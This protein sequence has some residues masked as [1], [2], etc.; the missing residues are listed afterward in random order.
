MALRKVKGNF[1]RMFDKNLT[2]LVRGIRN[3]K[4]NEVMPVCVC[5]CVRTAPW[6][7]RCRDLTSLP[8]PALPVF[9]IVSLKRGG[10]L[11][12]FSVPGEVHRAVYRGDQAGAAAGQC[13]GQSQR[14]GQADIC[15]S[16]AYVNFIWAL[17]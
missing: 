1:E 9:I 4:E 5:T 13:G 12:L 8:I 10:T 15:K 7:P 17:T 3:N 16:L 6:F 2:D 11:L 14:R